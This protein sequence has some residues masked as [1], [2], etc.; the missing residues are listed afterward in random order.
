VNGVFVTG[1]DTNV[2]KT[3]V[4]CALARRAHARGHKVFAFKPI[5]TG[6]TSTPNGYLGADQELLAVAA[7]DWQTGA[8]R[9]LYR[10]PLPAAPLVAAQQA[11]SAIDLELVER[12]MQD[13]AAQSGASW[14]LVEG[15]GG[16]RVPITPD[17]DMAALARRLRLPVLVVA[18]AGLGTIN[19]S[20][21]TLEAIE[22]DGLSVAGLVLSR[23]ET[24]DPA[25]AE[26]NLAQIRRC[27]TG[28]ILILSTDPLV[29]DRLLP[30]RP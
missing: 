9:G 20:L 24:D 30:S 14:T 12:T 15:A 7:G 26:S 21:L 4:A 29:L 18:R 25:A 28:T 1:T 3:F 27:W 11:G 10:F 19:H 17:A 22:R 2:G 6:C 23:H 16:W 5:E 8:L 13:G